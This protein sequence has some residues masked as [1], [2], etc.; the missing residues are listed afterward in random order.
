MET[1]KT[2]LIINQTAGSPHHGMVY[3]NYYIAR[4]WVKQGHKAIIISGSYFHNFSKLPETKGLFTKEEIDGIEYWWVKLPS[5]S[6]SRSAGRLL[7]L[8]IFPFLLLFFPFWRLSKPQTVIV[9][10][11]PH[12]SIFNAW[13]WAR[14]WGATLV[15][16]VRDIWPLTI[17]KLGN[18]SPWHPVI[19]FLSFFERLAYMAADRVVSVL[20]LANKHF[21]SRG[22]LPSKFA[23]I[24]NGVDTSIEDFEDS[25]VA[26]SVATIAKN[27]KVIIYAGSFGIANNLD[28]MI[29]AAQILK[30]Q[31]KLHFIF[32]G[33]GPH[34]D[35]LKKRAA[36]LDNVSFFGPVP[37]KEIPAI[38][39]HAHMGYVGLMKSDLFKHGVSPN[40]LFDYMAARKSVIMAIDT[41][42]NIVEK[43]QCGVAVTSC[44][45]QDIAEA[46]RHL[47]SKTNEELEELGQNGRNY[48]EKNHTYLSLAKKYI[49]VAEEGRRP[50]EESA[51]WIASPFWIGFWIVILSG[52]IAHFLLP[53]IT[54]HLF[55]DGISTFLN[56]PHIYHKLAK[57]LVDLPWSEFSFSPEGQFP[58][59]ILGFIYKITGISKPFMFLPV[60]GVMAGLTIRTIASCL[61]VL[62]VRGRWWPLIIG[63][64]FTVS[65][66]SISWMIY[67]HKDAFIVPGVLLIAWTFMSVTLR[68]IRMRHVASLLIG[69]CLVFTSKSYFAELFFAGTLLAIPFAWRQP[70]SKLGKYGRVIFFSFGLILFLIVAI[71]KRGYLEDGQN[72]PILDSGST[73]ISSTEILPRHLATRQNWID[74]PGGIFVN[75]PLLAL[76]YTRER[77]LFERPRGNT[78][79]APEVHLDSGWKTIQFLPKAMQ[80]SLFEPLPFTHIEGEGARKFLYTAVQFEMLLVYASL[81]FLIFS[82][83]QSWHPAVFVC[84]SF[85][86]PFLISLGVA[87]PNIGTINRYRFPFIILIKLAGLAALWNADR[88]K[89]P[90]RLLFWIDPPK[91]DRK[92]KKVLFLVPDDVTFL[93]QRLVM[94]KGAQN[95]GYDVHVASEDTG[96]SDKITKLGFTFHQLDLNRGGLNPIADFSAFIRLT[97]LLARLRPDILQ[98]VSIKPV[99]YGAT[100]GTIVGLNRIVCLVNGLGYAFQA[101]GLK[102]KFFIRV[103]KALYRNAL[104]LPGVR[105]IFQNPDDRDYFVSSHLVDAQKTI[106]IRGSGVNT[107]KFRPTAQPHNQKPVVLFVGRLLKSKGVDDLINATKILKEEKVSFI[108]RIVGEPDERNPEALPVGYIEEL[109]KQG[110]I[111]WMGRQSDMPKFYREADI[112]V[113][114]QQNR[115]GLPL[116]LLEASSSARTI[117][118]TDVPGCRE[119]V[120]HNVNGLMIPPKNAVELAKALKILLLDPELRKKFGEAGAK[121]VE[122]EFSAEIVQKQLSAVYESL[123]NDSV[124]LDDN[125]IH[126]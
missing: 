46:V 2:F 82:G 6:K 74:L 98:T 110:V 70:A 14:Y 59:G 104:A 11:P 39:S 94:A 45:P 101:K 52:S 24:P 126:A 124:S 125:L 67:P 56:D 58:A 10:G 68:R 51:R 84:L 72:D 1:K 48:L 20:A 26:R 19:L 8:F 85:S 120:R 86:L 106:L 113:L 66:T 122:K 97:F 103:A 23:Y 42:D 71:L 18:I 38:L 34:K 33:D 119:A 61:D 69:A 109:H 9:S 117:V 40:K 60:L 47:A 54:P 102:G 83:P 53:L 35:N 16:E 37:K 88:N 17:I 93:I 121:I 79:Y 15:Y 4:E 112:I 80:L 77:F 57:Q 90:G 107:R 118:A 115:E 92:K 65:P 25:E 3:R 96:V 91:I 27:K 32:I 116:T 89:W 63:I 50:V 108:L 95:A 123:L 29:D 114:P 73:E 21:E 105:V 13:I 28:Q 76:A 22:M 49:Q 62:G 111:E 30:D 55:Q 99:I 78:N 100:A 41:E 64:L 31:T 5:Y 44:S 12:L 75:K 87:V 7:T 36:S 81:L 43:A